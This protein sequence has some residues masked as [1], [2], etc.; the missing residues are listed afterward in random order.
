MFCQELTLQDIFTSTEFL[1]WGT[2]Y[3]PFT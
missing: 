3:I 1:D 2:L